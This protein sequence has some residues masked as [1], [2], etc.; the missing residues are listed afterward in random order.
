MATPVFRDGSA[1][2]IARDN[3]P[4]YVPD[5]SYVS[6]IGLPPPM[7]VDPNWTPPNDHPFGEGT[8]RDIAINMPFPRQIPNGITNPSTGQPETIPDPNDPNSPPPL[9]QPPPPMSDPLGQG[10]GSQGPTFVPD[11]ESAGRNYGSFRRISQRG[12][13]EYRPSNT[14]ELLRKA[15]ARRLG[16]D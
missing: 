2:Q 7:M 16:L 1:R 14:A 5:L 4:A 8:P 10:P 11:G 9:N 12:G 13:P 6:P 15:A 3:P